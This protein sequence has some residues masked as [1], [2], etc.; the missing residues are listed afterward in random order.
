MSTTAIPEANRFG[1]H[2]GVLPSVLIGSVGMSLP[3]AIPA[4]LAALG[5]VRHFSESQTGL[6]AMADVA[7]I[8]IGSFGCAVL[9]D[10]VK[11]LNWRRTVMLGM[12]LAL[13]ANLVSI[14]APSFEALLVLRPIAGLGC[15]MAMAVVYA[16]MA[17]GDAARNLGVFTVAQLGVGWLAVLAMGAISTQYG[18]VGLFGLIS[19]SILVALGFAT[20]VPPASMRRSMALTSAKPALGRVSALGWAGIGSVVLFYSGVVAV[21]SYL[22]Y[23]GAAWGVKQDVAN[24]AAAYVLFAGM[25]GGAAA[26]II[27][28]RFGFVKPMIIGFSGLLAATAIFFVAAPVQAFI[29]LAMLFG[30]CFSYVLNYQ[31]EAVITVDPTSSTAMFVNVAALVG[32]SAGPVVGGA[33]ATGDFRIVNGT[34]LVMMAL[35]M[36][37]VLWT[38]ARSRTKDK[39]ATVPVAIANKLVDPR[40]YA[41]LDGIEAIF[42]DMRANDP[43]PMAHPDKYD[44]FWIATRYED[45]QEIERNAEV[46]SNAAGSVMLLDRASIAYSIDT[47]GEPNVT[48][49]AVEVDGREHKDLR[50]IAFPRFTPKAIKDLEDSIRLLARRSVSEM[51]AKGT[52]CDFAQDVGWVYP[53]RVVMA[54]L[55]LPGDDE[56]FFLHNAHMLHAANDPDINTSGKDATSNEAMRMID[57]GLKD[58]HDYFEGRT[59]KLRQQPD[60]TLTSLIANARIDGEYLTARQLHGY[61]LIA[62]TAGHDTTAFTTSMSMWVLA[63]RPELVARLKA[64]P[65]DIGLF[66]EEAIRWATPVKNFMRTALSDT[67]VAGKKIRKGDWIMLAYQSANR[68]ESIFDDPFTFDIDRKR[69]PSLTFGTGPHICLGQHLARMEMRV[70]WE[71]LLPQIADVRLNGTPRR[72]ISNFV[73]GP[74]DVPIAFRWEEAAAKQVH[75]AVLA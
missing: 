19:A 56:D 30:F 53:L 10:L 18:A 36:A 27:G 26:A 65:A 60:G 68:D 32:F 31:F 3:N 51:R 67:E 7:G 70:L 34:A 11:R 62:T 71:E 52:M 57:E 38:I 35:S 55:G 1:L 42:R 69:I 59:A 28:S 45:I 39:R 74:K 49:S 44:P 66:V 40:A 21:F 43:F 25:F 33:L 20:L 72:T 12:A 14:F 41:E 24:G 47:F 2:P 54:T 48:R 8:T 15:G 61:Y 23:M 50:M 64:N 75:D 73:C 22:V 6:V 4:Y 5:L 16:V 46:F 37:M 58:L 63:Q 9:P 29:P 17:E 13:L